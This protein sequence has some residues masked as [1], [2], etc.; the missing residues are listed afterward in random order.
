MSNSQDAVTL[1]PKPS[2]RTRVIDVVTMA[3]SIA[4]LVFALTLYFRRPQ[5]RPQEVPA[6][7][8]VTDWAAVQSPGHLMGAVDTKHTIVV[9]EDYQC[10]YC[11]E[12]QPVLRRLVTERPDIRVV[13]RQ[14]PLVNHPHAF[15]AAVAAECAAV[16]ARYAP[17]HDSLYARQREIGTR[18]W[19]SFG[20]L[21]GVKDLDALEKCITSDDRAPN[22][23]NTDL[24]MAQ[25]LQ[26]TGT[27]SVIVDGTLL[28]VPS[29]EAIRKAL[30]K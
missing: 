26:L 17:M 30:A 28:A 19:R 14:F 1:L 18:S 12:L 20:R 27:P 3:V 16:Q 9:F 8:P 24:R 22:A 13:F 6:D 15:A 11:A 7:R 5:P 10:P 2:R 23:V 29:E 21:A 4:S 25:T